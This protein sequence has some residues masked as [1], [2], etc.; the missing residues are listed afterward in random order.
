MAKVAPSI[1]SADFAKMGSDIAKLEKW[2]ASF[3]HCDVMDGMFVP[4]MSFGPQMIKAIRKHTLL[5]IDVHLMILQPERYVE[6]FAKSGADIITVH[7]EATMHVCRTLKLI[8]AQGV[9]AGIALNPATSLVELENILDDIDIVLLMTVNPGFGGQIFIPSMINKIQKL[10]NMIEHSGK[11]IEIEVDGGVTVQNA[12]AIK[13]AG[14]DILVAGSA[15]FNSANP[16]K[17]VCEIAGIE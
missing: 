5:P 9:K 16:K 12:L 7:Q 14:A 15:I 8:A 10:K 6:V 2:G 11:N 1:L 3:I 13:K 4:N 17:S